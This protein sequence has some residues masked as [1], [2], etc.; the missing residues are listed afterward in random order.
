MREKAIE[1]VKRHFPK[2]SEKLFATKRSFV[3][4]GSVT[5]GGRYISVDEVKDPVAAC[6]NEVLTEHGFKYLK[7]QSAFK[8]NS[9]SGLD[10]IRI[11]SYDYTHYHFDFHFY[12]RI[13]AVQKHLTKYN[14]ENQFNSQSDYKKQE[15]TWV[16]YGNIKDKIE[17][18]SFNKLAEE[19]ISLLVFLNNEILPYFPLLDS[20]EK[21]NDTLN[22]PEKDESNHFSYFSRGQF[23]AY[24]AEAG[25]IAAKLV[26]DPNYDKIMKKHLAN[27]HAIEEK[28]TK[29]DEFLKRELSLT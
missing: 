15:T 23:Y 17:A 2:G 21:L 13:D 28:I 14:F 24:A 18:I 1:I 9:S 8:R 3:S 7:S 11:V 25:L 26:N 10:L 12:K 16:C 20:M 29:L 27:E 5:E 19:T 4:V 6:L 22:Y